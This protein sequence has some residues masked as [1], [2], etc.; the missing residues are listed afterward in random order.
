MIAHGFLKGHRLNKTEWSGVLLAF[1]G[2]VY[3]VSP[4]ISA[5]P[6]EGFILMTLSGFGWGMYSSENLKLELRNDPGTEKLFS[7]IPGDKLTLADG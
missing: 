1:G 7:V 6:I 2:F 5:P 4:G 3:L